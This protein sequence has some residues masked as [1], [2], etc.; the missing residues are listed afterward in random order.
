MKKYKLR[1]IE[2]DPKET[3]AGFDMQVS[4]GLYICGIRIVNDKGLELAKLDLRDI[5]HENVDTLWHSHRIPQGH[6]II[7]FSCSKQWKTLAQPGLLLWIP[8]Q[9]HLAIAQE[10]DRQQK[11]IKAKN[12]EQDKRNFRSYYKPDEGYP[13][14]RKCHPNLNHTSFTDSVKNLLKIEDYNKT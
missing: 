4:K 3:V 12:K 5:M 13:Q 6:E 7:G 10:R 8:T 2:I 14:E 9:K 11:V 1:T